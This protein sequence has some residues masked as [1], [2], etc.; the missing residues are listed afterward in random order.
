MNVLTRQTT[1][2]LAPFVLRLA[3]GLIFLVHGLLKF[4]HMAGAVTTFTKIG[5]PLPDVAV[6]AIAVLEILGGI[7]LILGPDLA[8]RVL[9]LLLAIE[10]LVAILL[11]ERGSGFVGGYE[12]EVIL[13]AALLALVLSGPGRPALT[14]K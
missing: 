6:P 14:R 5:V 1:S 12:F 4:L 9:A 3:L 7:V 8:M 2:E 13:L 11:A 10:M